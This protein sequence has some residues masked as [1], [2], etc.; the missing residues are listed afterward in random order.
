[1]ANHTDVIIVGSGPTGLS[2]ALALSQQGLNTICTGPRSYKKKQQAGSLDT[3]TTAL[4]Q[5]SVQYLKNIGVWEACQP[6][7]QRLKAIRIIDAS[8]RLFQAP[9][10]LFD[11]HELGIESFG[12][13]IPNVNL[14]ECLHTALEQQDSAHYIETEAVTDIHI[15]KDHATLLLKEGGTLSAQLIIGAD[16]RHSLCRQAAGIDT[17]AW[18][19]D[20]SAI[21]CNFSHAKDHEDISNE[22]HTASGPFTTVPL[23]QNKSSLVW[24]ERPHRVEQLMALTDDDFRVK[25][26]R[27]LQGLLG[28]ISE[29]GP[30]TA[31]PLATQ[32][33]KTFAQRRTVLIGEAA[34]VMPPIGAQGLN[35]GFRDCAM[36]AEC[37][38]DVKNETQDFGG[39]PLLS[40]YNKKRRADV[41][42]RT[43]AVDALNRSLLSGFL[44]LQLGRFVGMNILGSVGPLRRFLMRQGMQPDFVVPKLFKAVS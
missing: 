28:N 31:F 34:H 37:L 19:Y 13:N 43:I 42:S 39:Q 9:E 14:I 25:V 20:Q 12:Y 24:V 11:S 33:A 23:S 35:L 38:S 36:L 29:L 4:F 17:F 44:P 22:F 27:Q 5:G 3:R 26:I 2:L 16:G 8:N 30:R 1:M 32:T 40:L 18:K 21:A 6:F 41:W 15:A 7:A 10:T